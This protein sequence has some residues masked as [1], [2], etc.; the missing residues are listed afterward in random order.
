LDEPSTTTVLGLDNVPLNLPVAGA[1]SRVLAAFVDYLVVVLAL[2]ALGGLCIFLGTTQRVGG[3]WAIGVFIVGAF[4]IEYGYFAT[5]EIAWE[6]HTLGK[7]ALGLRVVT[8]EGGR[9]GSTAYLIRNAVRTVDLL[10]GVPLIATDPL[11]RR[12][13]DRLAGTL[14]VHLEPQA[15]EPILRKSPQGWSTD[16]VAL[17]EAFLRRA[18]HLEPWRADRM[19]RQ[20]LDAIAHDDPALLAGIDTEN[21]VEAL[22]KAVEG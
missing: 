6:G 9:P 19:S 7:W 22:R 17:L 8:R 10:V 21:G 14:V 18:P 20:L 5:S 1:G 3:L 12:L 13:G 11:A 15:V 16:E 2:I 4:L